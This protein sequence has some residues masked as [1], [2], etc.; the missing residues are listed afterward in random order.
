[1][2]KIEIM[3]WSEAIVHGRTTQEELISFKLSNF[4]ALGWG[5]TT[6]SKW[7][8]TADASIPLDD[9]LPLACVSFVDGVLAG[10][11][12]VITNDLPNYP[13]NTPIAETFVGDTPVTDAANPWFA[14]HFVNEK[15]S[16]LGVSRLQEAWVI[17]Q[18]RNL[19]AEGRWPSS[20]SR[21]WLF[22]ERE[23]IAFLPEMY[24]RLGWKLHR[25]FL[26][27]GVMRWVMYK[28]VSES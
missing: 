26:Y 24:E 17:E 3:S 5:G 21:L 8:G 10:M 23:P 12:F 16:R 14:G 13:M 4:R 18:S 25:T 11:S 1:M 27:K 2:P 28:D 22:T 19:Y 15:F 9:R 7:H 20:D 6:V